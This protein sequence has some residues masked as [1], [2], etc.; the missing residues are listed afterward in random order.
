MKTWNLAIRQQPS[1]SLSCSAYERPAEHVLTAGRRLWPS[2]SRILT[3]LR[4]RTTITATVAGQATDCT[5][6]AVK[7]S[8]FN[9][10]H[11]PG[12]GAIP[13][14]VSTSTGG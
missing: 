3:G 6:K 9:M 10:H 8:P 7:A 2:H 13:A 4:S 12:N 14:A 1:L 5:G 11:N